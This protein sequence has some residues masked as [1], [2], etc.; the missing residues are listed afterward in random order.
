MKQTIF[1]T[2]D[3]SKD[4]SY[5]INYDGINI[6]KGLNLIEIANRQTARQVAGFLKF[7]N[8]VDIFILSKDKAIIKE[9]YSIFPY[10]RLIYEPRKMIFDLNKTAKEL[11][12]LNI[13]TICLDSTYANQ[14]TIME[15]HRLGIKVI[16]RV[17]T[18]TEAYEA[19]LAGADGILGRDIKKVVIH[20]DI[21]TRPFLSAHRGYHKSF[22]EN[23]LEAGQEAYKL[24]ADFIEM[25]VHLSQN[26]VSV[27]N[28]APSL[29]KAY[30]KDLLIRKNTYNELKEARHVL[31]GVKQETTIAAL[32][33][34]D[35]TIP[36][37]MG[38]IVEAKVDTKRAIK[39]M[40]KIVN[41]M[42][43]PVLI[44]SFLPFAIVRMNTYIKKVKSGMLLNLN[45]K[46]LKFP[47]L[48]KL[49]HKYNLTLHP[50]YIH[51]RPDFIEA[52]QKRMIGLATWG[53]TK[54]QMYSAIK[55][56]Y[57]LINSDYI[58]ALINIPKRIMVDKHINYTIGEYKKVILTD[59]NH[60]LLSLVPHILF[61]NPHS[62]VFDEHG[63]ID[64]KETGTAYVYFTYSVFHEKESLTYASDL[65]TITIKERG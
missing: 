40:A 5:L 38:F 23:S 7:H 60:N 32:L 48:L 9:I 6:L 35:K 28:H 29:G 8:H 18:Q 52:F 1:I 30:D 15:F 65:V 62:I 50:Y 44:M 58:D 49:I 59:D 31:K 13:F 12:A 20:T 16:I 51:N 42:T 25:D 63:I 33:E 46:N 24:G 61:D 27:V 4:M 39:K 34:F 54:A 21:Y 57:D 26:G 53:L 36:E 11:F 22:P 64:A 17:N 3:S 41:S 19:T 10:I 37:D 43:R 47:A 45:E 55:E 2:T 14:A 56:G